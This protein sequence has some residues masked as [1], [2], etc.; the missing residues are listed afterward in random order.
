MIKINIVWVKIRVY[1]NTTAVPV[2]CLINYKIYI[3]CMQ[4]V[5]LSVVSNSL[6][7][8]RLQPP[9]LLYPGN[10][11]RKNT[12]VGCHFLLQGLFL[13]QALNP[14]SP[15]LQANSSLSEPPERHGYLTIR[16]TLVK[17]NFFSLLQHFCL[18]RG[19]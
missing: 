15:A 14:W 12:G 2:S 18:I 10:S 9:R 6:R 17:D 16:R 3:H 7:P 11:P 5:S 8:Q 19:Y 4:C 13:T 1:L